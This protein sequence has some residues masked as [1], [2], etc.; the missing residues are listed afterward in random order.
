MHGHRNPTPE[1]SCSLQGMEAGFG[2]EHL[3]F[4]R[5]AGRQNARCGSVVGYHNPRI[6]RKT[7]ADEPVDLDVSDNSALIH[8]NYLLA[9]ASAQPKADTVQGIA[10]CFNR[11]DLNRYLDTLHCG[12]RANPNQITCL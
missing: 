1:Q 7:R 4:C 10:H 6:A 5:N 2:A 3:R 9:T 11:S 12:P 8:E